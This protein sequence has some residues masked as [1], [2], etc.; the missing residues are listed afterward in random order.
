MKLRTFDGEPARGKMTTDSLVSPDGGPVLL[1]ND[2]PFSPEEAEFL[3]ESATEK[4]M[5]MLL[6][7][8]YDLAE[9]E[10][11][12]EETGEDEEDEEIEPDE[13]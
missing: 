4:E 2:E 9:W 1:V 11:M 10:G 6:E 5:E 3:L 13:D 8:G 7:G 12:D